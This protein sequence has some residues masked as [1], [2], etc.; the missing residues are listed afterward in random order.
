MGDNISKIEG[1]K[2]KTIE[3]GLDRV[4]KGEEEAFNWNCENQYLLHR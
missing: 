1:S 2:R 3:M 4:E